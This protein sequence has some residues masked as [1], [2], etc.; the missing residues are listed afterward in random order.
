M[1][2]LSMYSCRVEYSPTGA[3]C[4]KP[5]RRSSSMRPK[6]LGLSKR[7]MQHQSMLP[8]AP[9]NASERQSPM[10]P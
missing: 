2:D 7:G 9:T 8:S 3:S 4:Q 1:L 6:M 10:M 5:P